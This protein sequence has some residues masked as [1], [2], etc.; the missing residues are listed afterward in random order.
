[1]KFI[2]YVLILLFLFSCKG[3]NSFADDI[4]LVYPKNVKMNFQKFN[5]DINDFGSYLIYKGKLKDSIFV[6]YY[7]HI[8]LPPPPP[9]PPPPPENYSKN[10]KIKDSL[11]NVRLKNIF[12]NYFYDENFHLKFSEKTKK[13]DSLSN[14][15]IKIIV[16]I[17]DT[18][19]LYSYFN[20]T[21]RTFKA[22]P[23]FIKNISRDT[24]KMVYFFNRFRLNSKGKWEFIRNGNHYYGACIPPPYPEYFELSP[25]EILIYA[26]PFFEGTMKQKFKLKIGGAYSNE[27]ES[28]IN[29]F[30]IKNQEFT[31]LDE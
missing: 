26:I 11:E 16:N 30:V 8:G 15:N 31:F 10:F 29:D 28:S 2:I 17:N 6:K 19:P 25:N 5:Q 14:K 27:Y 22:Y 12:S 1:M 9:P 3:D 7:K 18:I 23:V 20:D 4:A 13:L 24:L 21:L